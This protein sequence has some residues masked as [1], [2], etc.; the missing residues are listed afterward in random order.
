MKTRHAAAL[1]LVGWYL[2][3]PPSG[4]DD[5]PIVTAPFSQWTDHHTYDTAAHCEA[6]RLE[7]IDAL[8]NSELDAIEYFQ[9]SLCVSAD[10]PRLNQ[11]E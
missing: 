5:K 3:A 9:T 7:I 11:K 4:P 8:P 1:A 10:D 2:L 6:R